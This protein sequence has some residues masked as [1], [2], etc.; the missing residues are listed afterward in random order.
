VWRTSPAVVTDDEGV[1]RD[2]EIVT[3]PD[4]MHV[5]QTLLLRA[6]EAG[7]RGGSGIDLQGKCI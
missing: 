7:I 1:G 3:D 6:P 4:D 5:T 2:I